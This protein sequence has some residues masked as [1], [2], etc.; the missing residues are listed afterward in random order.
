MDIFPVTFTKMSG[1]GNDFILI[2]NRSFQVASEHQAD[3]ARGVC[4]RMFSAGADGVIFVEDSEQADFKWRFYNS[5]G[6]VAEMCGNGARCVARFAYENGIVSTDRMCFETLA[7]IIDA[8]VF[9]EGEVQV[10]LSPPVGYRQGLIAQL[11]GASHQFFF[12][13]TGVP[14]AVLFVTDKDV[15]VVK[16]GRYI[17]FHEQFGSQGTNVDFVRMLA[18]GTLHVRTYERG[19]EDETRAC[20]TGAVAAALVA[21]VQ[22]KITSPVDVITSGGDRLQVAFK[23]N[24]GAQGDGLFETVFLKGP[25]RK[26]YTGEFTAESLL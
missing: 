25:A 17:R 21:A 8:R 12:L 16:W 24:E 13:N 22:K 2:D 18:D 6:S 26:I 19:V 23:I 1:T 3:F 9:D 20:G 7:G 4:R 15:D 5:D 10:R 11:D 14:H